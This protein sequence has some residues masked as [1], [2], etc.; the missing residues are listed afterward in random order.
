MH[1]TPRRPVLARLL[2]GIRRGWRDFV[3]TDPVIAGGRWYASEVRASNNPPPGECSCGEPAE[4]G[5]KDCR[6]C[7]NGRW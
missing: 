3:A 6:E 1:E 2:A 4:A 7:Y 5:Y